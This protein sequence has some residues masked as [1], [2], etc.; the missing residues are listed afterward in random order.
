MFHLF[1]HKKARDVIKK[2]FDNIDK[3]IKKLTKGRKSFDIVRTGAFIDLIE[4]NLDGLKTELDEFAKEEKKFIGFRL[5]FDAEIDRHI[6]NAKKVIDNL[7]NELLNYKTL[8]NDATNDSDR[9]AILQLLKEEETKFK[10]WGESYRE[11]RME[12][13][14][15]FTA[16]NMAKSMVT[17]PVGSTDGV[18]WSKIERIVRLLGGQMTLAGKHPDK[19]TFPGALRPVPLSKDMGVRD[20]AHQIIVQLRSIYPRK[21]I[22]ATQLIA[23][24]A[25][26]D[27][28]LA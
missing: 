16:E 28:A 19:I 14:K 6:I 20:L 25:Q 2:Q 3:E 5:G 15:E 21:E 9:I 18:A 7:K 11:S 4:N 13:L 10:I 8:F 23:A 24:F 17:S 22:N 26:G 1:K 27:L 12:E